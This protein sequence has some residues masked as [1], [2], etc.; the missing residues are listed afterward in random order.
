MK[1]ALPLD[2]MTAADK[3]ETMEVLWDDLCKNSNEFASPSWHGD[4]LAERD[5]NLLEC[6]EP[7]HDWEKAKERIRRSV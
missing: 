5:K 3:L 4:I 7:I 1:V 6:K 2:R